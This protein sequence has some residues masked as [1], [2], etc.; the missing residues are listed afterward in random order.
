MNDDYIKDDKIKE[1]EVN[2]SNRPPEEATE[3]LDPI[4]ELKSSD[5]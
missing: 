2:G 4:D 5:E 1:D 3:I